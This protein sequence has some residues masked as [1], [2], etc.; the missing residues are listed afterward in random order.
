MRVSAIIAAYNEEQTLGEVLSA[1]GQ[2]S[3]IH[4]I[5]VVSDGSS[6]RTV[7]IAREHGVK[8]IALLTNHGK[9]CAMR[10]G[11]EQ[12]RGDVLFFVDGDM[13]NLTQQHIES[14]VLPVVKGRCDMNVGVRH[15]GAVRNFLHLKA[16]IGPVLSGIRVMRREVFRAVPPQYM[17]R[18]KIE[19]AL[20]YFCERAG[21]R[22]WNTVV[23]NLGHVIKEQK[24]GIG[25]G[26][27]GRL[28]MTREVSLLHFD[29]FL[30]QSWKW[31]EPSEQPRVEFETYE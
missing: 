6:D 9:G 1:L 27:A 21:Y 7:S 12:A 5:I 16:H 15:R 29:L 20:N 11:V 2:S 26:L 28:R 10:V 14:L 3:L 24:R 30:F 19:L 8:T 31:V 25:D 13:L 4:E 18:F 17:E 22:Q 23:R